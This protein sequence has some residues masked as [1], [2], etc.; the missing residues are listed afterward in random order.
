[1]TAQ[2]RVVQR[3]EQ[4][5]V[6]AVGCVR[7]VQRQPR[8]A[9]V[10]GHG[11]RGPCVHGGHRRTPLWANAATPRAPSCA[12]TCATTSPISSSRPSAKDCS[13]LACTSRLM[14]VTALR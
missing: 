4:L 10:D 12:L 6:E 8:N 14:A 5:N 9:V 7:A 2:D 11:Y 1:M 3:L 13:R